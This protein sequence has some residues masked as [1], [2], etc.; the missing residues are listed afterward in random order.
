MPQ[1]KP[2]NWTKL[3]SY[4]YFMLFINILKIYYTFLWIHMIYK[5][6]KKNNKKWF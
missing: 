6:F 5:N 1:M 3:S 2:Y 4:S